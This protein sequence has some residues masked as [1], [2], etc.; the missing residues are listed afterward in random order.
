MALGDFVKQRYENSKNKFINDPIANAA[1]GLISDFVNFPKRLIGRVQS[2]I[3]LKQPSYL[4]AKPTPSPVMPTATPTAVPTVMPT[5][6]PTVA[7]TATPTVAPTAVPTRRPTAVPTSRPTATPTARPTAVPTKV[8]T[9]I[10][11]TVT[12]TPTLP[13]IKPLHPGF[14]MRSL[15]SLPGL[16]FAGENSVPVPTTTPTPTSM[17]TPVPDP[18]EKLTMETFDK[19][20]VPRS[21]AYGIRQAEG[22][23]IGRN[24]SFNIG[25]YDSNPRAAWSF[26]SPLAEATV[27]AKLLSG[28]SDPRYAATQQFYENPDLFLAEVEKAGYAGD[29]KTW[30]ARSISQGGAGKFYDY[31]RDFV[32]DTD[33]YKKWRKK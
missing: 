12:P 2:A 10:M 21:V 14:D 7:P 8:A 15:F 13:D 22:G 16:V 32:K 30:K 5:A 27:A 23:R 1:G 3:G 29:P 33:A 9:K 4:T 28:T 25:A 19:Y 11:P 17:P 26:N 24:N 6:T 18:Y 31:Y 20:K